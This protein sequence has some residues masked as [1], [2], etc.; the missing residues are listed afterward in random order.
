EY[1]WRRADGNGFNLCWLEAESRLPGRA[2]DRR[3][4]GAGAAST[5]AAMELIAVII[6]AILGWQHGTLGAREAKVIAIVVAGW[7]A[8]T[9][10]ASIPYLTVEGFVVTLI[11]HTAV[12]AVPYALAVLARRLIRRRK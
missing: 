7:T 10:A 4:T 1:N 9:T 5:K 6:G 2:G 11:W 12:V 3:L 8:V